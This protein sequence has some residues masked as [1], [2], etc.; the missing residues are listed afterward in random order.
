MRTITTEPLTEGIASALFRAFARMWQ[1]IETAL[2][3]LG[4]RNHH[5]WILFAIKKHGP[6]SQVGLMKHISVDRTTM[7]H[8]ID[9]LERLGLVERGRDAKDRRANVVRLKALGEE[10]LAQGQ[11]R[12]AES[13]TE[14]LKGLS[15]EEQE[16]LLALLVRLTNDE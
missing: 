16:Q 10:T 12:M 4:L 1:G 3:P 9:D 14:F 15:L 5:F 6:L 13:E 8:L 7:V 11:L 2:E